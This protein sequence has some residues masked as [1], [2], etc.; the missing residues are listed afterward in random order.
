[1]T[2]R[3]YVDEIIKRIVWMT[4]MKDIRYSLVMKDGML[5]RLHEVIKAKSGSMRY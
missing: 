4:D 3:D 5:I 2:A 1:M